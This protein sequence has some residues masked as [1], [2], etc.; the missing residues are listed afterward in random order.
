MKED[1]SSGFHL[2]QELLFIHEGKIEKDQ[3]IGALDLAFEKDRFL[4]DAEK[5]RN[6]GPPTFSAEEGKTLRI[7]SFQEK[8]P[9]KDFRGHHSPLATTSSE[10]DLDHDASS[11]SI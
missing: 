4:I 3:M 8:G 11:R 9:A 5:P 7:L 10:L 2:V 1:Q 6:R